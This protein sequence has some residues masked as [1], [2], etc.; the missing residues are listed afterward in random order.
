[1]HRA[2]AGRRA[3]GQGG[4]DLRRRIDRVRGGR[5]GVELD[6]GHAGEV[7]AVDG[8]ARTDRPARRGERRHGRR[9]AAAA[10]AAAGGE[11][12]GAVRRTEAG[13]PVVPDHARAQVRTAAGTVRPGGDVE[14]RRRVRV[15]VRRRV[16]GGAG[17]AREGVD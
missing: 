9:A 12:R 8:H 2:R 6:G 4:G 16:V 3:G 14:Q 13:R 5:G 17:D 10:T 15:R 11:G 1:R 7:G